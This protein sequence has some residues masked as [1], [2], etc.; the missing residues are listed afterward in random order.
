MSDNENNTKGD[1][2]EKRKPKS[3]TIE[4]KLEV[5]EYASKKS[6]HAASELYKIDRKRIR[7]WKEQK[8]DLENFK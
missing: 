2:Q 6:I 1:H 3:Y 8:N 5:I 4:K 7:E